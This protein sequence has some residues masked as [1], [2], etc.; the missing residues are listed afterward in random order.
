MK[1]NHGFTLI[2]L[3]VVISIIALLIALLLPALSKAR[4]AA[5]TAQCLSNLRQMTMAWY[6]HAIDNKGVPTT[7]WETDRTQWIVK[8]RGYWV[9]NEVRYC[10]S[11]EKPTF[12]YGVGTARLSWAM[13]DPG[14]QHDARVGDGGSYGYNNYFENTPQAWFRAGDHPEWFFTS[15]SDPVPTSHTPVLADC[16]WAEGGWPW[17]DEGLNPNHD[18]ELGDYSRYMARYALNRHSMAINVSRLDGSVQ[19]T[20]VKDLWQLRWHREWK[21]REQP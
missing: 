6:N 15:I 7:S 1:K 2:E 10:P 19:L 18:Y 12:A 13:Y 4:E 20:D 8:L 14:S 17:N 11:T 9:N 5:R 16:I 3:L 21:P